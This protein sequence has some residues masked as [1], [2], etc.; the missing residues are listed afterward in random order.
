[1][2]LERNVRIGKKMIGVENKVLLVIFAFIC[3]FCS[4]QR[5]VLLQT[6]WVLL[7]TKGPK[8]K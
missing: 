7:Q 2:V 5:W 4:K 6:K 3:G 1:M 8:R